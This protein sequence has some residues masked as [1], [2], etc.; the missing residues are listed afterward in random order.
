VV[1]GLHVQHIS[2]RALV[3]NSIGERAGLLEHPFRLVVVTAEADR[4][5]HRTEQPGPVGA[6]DV[7]QSSERALPC[8]DGFRNPSSPG[9]LRHHRPGQ[10]AKCIGSSQ[11]LIQVQ[12]LVHRAQGVVPPAYATQRPS[13]PLQ[14]LGASASIAAFEQ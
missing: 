2:E 7:S 1:A 11:R 12:C 14:Q 13:K 6:G 5:A 10:P 8:Q 3:A 4:P 9:Q